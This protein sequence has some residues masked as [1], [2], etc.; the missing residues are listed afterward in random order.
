MSSGSW[1]NPK[2]RRAEARCSRRLRRL[3]EAVGVVLLLLLVVS[4]STVLLDVLTTNT[5]TSRSEETG[6]FFFFFSN[7]MDFKVRKLRNMEA[8]MNG[9]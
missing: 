6:V 5:G 1:T 8:S 9:I 2:V 4:F 3:A 7:Y